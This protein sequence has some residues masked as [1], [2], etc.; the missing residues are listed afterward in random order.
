MRLL[1][2][3]SFF[4][5][6]FI[7]IE[8]W[9]K[10]WSLWLIFVPNS[11]SPDLLVDKVCGL[12][13]LRVLTNSK[14]LDLRTIE[15]QVDSCLRVLTNSKSPDPQIVWDLLFTSAN[16]KCLKDTFEIKEEHIEVRI[17]KYL[18]MHLVHCVADITN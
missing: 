3:Q 10:E 8:I 7:L 6:S 14:S 2:L 15:I 13:R 11:K 18:W 16:K 17:I 9:W 12:L 5:L 1:F 4:L